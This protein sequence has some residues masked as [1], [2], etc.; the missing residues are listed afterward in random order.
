MLSISLVPTL[1]IQRDLYDLPA[2]PGRFRAYVDTMTSADGEMVLPL[3]LM[4]PMAKP[5]VAA[6]LDALLAFDAEGVARAAIDEA[7]LLLGPCA[8]ANDEY[9]VALVV[10]DDARGGWTHRQFTDAS[11]RFEDRHAIARGW[12]TVVLWSSDA[13]AP[14]TVRREVMSAVF[15][16]LYLRRHGFPTTLDAMLRQE[17]YAA[18]FAGEVPSLDATVLAHART[19]VAE[20]RATTSAQIIF[21]CL[22]GDA[23][24][25]SVGYDPL[26]LGPDAGLEVGLA[27]ALASGVAPASLL[28]EL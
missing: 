27:D 8:A 9:S 2:G 13:P 12:I 15:R 19:I 7:R 17:G 22:F 26:G 23:A 4:N 25:T 24:A 3:S 20:Y 21:A 28:R 10:V 18:A 5:H 16:V 1:K 6:V 11:H 14:A